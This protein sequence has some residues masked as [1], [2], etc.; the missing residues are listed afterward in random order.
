MI[1][2]MATSVI[3]LPFGIAAIICA[4]VGGQVDRKKEAWRDEQS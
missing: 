3:L 4:L 1:A 2:A